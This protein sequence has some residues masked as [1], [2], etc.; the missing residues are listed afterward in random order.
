MIMRVNEIITVGPNYYNLFLCK[1]L[2]KGKINTKKKAAK[3]YWVSTMCHLFS[4]TLSH[5]FALKQMGQMVLFSSWLDWDM[6]RLFNFYK[7]THLVPGVTRFNSSFQNQISLSM[8][9]IILSCLKCN[10]TNIHPTSGNSDL[11][12][13]FQKEKDMRKDM[14]FF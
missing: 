13:L 5:L 4:Q 12:G 8:L 9:F 7:V 14:E 3:I 2:Y 11:L 6:E 1:L 10:K